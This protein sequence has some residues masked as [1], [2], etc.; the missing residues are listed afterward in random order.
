MKLLQEV[1]LYRHRAAQARH[2]SRKSVLLILLARHRASLAL[3]P[4][5]PPLTRS[6]HPQSLNGTNTY[7][8]LSPPRSSGSEAILLSAPFVSLIGGPNLRG[9]SILLALARFLRGQN[10]WAKDIVLVWADG[11]D[12]G[13]EAFLKGYHRVGARGGL[14]ARCGK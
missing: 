13:V 9:L 8:L 4:P 7:A 12:E 5:L 3:V 6:S 2:T 14:S 1:G 11:K 10:H